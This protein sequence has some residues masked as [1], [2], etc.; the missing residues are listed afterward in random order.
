MLAR[1]YQSV[2]LGLTMKHFIAADL[3]RV[4]VYP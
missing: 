3:K 4:V 1:Q 2:N